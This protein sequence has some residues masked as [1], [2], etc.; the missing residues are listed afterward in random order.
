MGWEWLRFITVALA[1][2][3]IIQLSLFGKRTREP[4][5]IAP[6]SWLL[7]IV[8]YSI[9]KYIVGNDLDYYDA[10]VIW[11]NIILVVG[12]VLIIAGGFVFRDIKS[13]TFRR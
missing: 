8:G 7:L 6:I 12:I 9:F 4:A 5:V 1:I 3:A 2:I 13:W 11:L 10:S